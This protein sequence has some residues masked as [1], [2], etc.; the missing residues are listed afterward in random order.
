MHKSIQFF[1]I[2]G[3]IL[4]ACT[5]T[6]N[7]SPPT[8]APTAPT[9]IIPTPPA[10]EPACNSIEVEPTP[11]PDVPSL[12]PPVSADEHVRGPEDAIMTLVV[13]ND[14]QCVDCN[15]LS[16][17]RE[18]FEKQ[19]GNVRI[20]YRYYPYT[21]FFD[22]GELAA[23]AAE[24]ASNQDKFWEMHDL[25]FEKQVEWVDLPVDDFESWVTAQAQEIG[26]DKTQFTADFNSAETIETVQK[27]VQEGTR[28][29]IPKLP[30]ILMNGQIY[31][32]P[33]DYESF[34]QVISLLKLGERQF[35]QCPPTVIDMNKQYIAKLETE[36]GEIVLQLYPDKAPLTVNSFVYLA[37]QGWFDGITFHRVLPGFVAQTGDP[38]GTGQGN[39]GYI[40][41]NEIDP[42][43]KFDQAGLVAMAN[44]GPDS[45]GSQFFITYGPAPHLDGGYTIFGKVLS[46]MEVVEQLTPRDPQPGSNLPPGDKLVSVTIEEK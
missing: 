5:P 18:L 14:F 39:P 36:K 31:N 33:V 16:L 34:S 8:V 38:S 9:I 20:A 12:F 21:N 17:S 13:Y 32:G 40:F 37:R 22:K 41:Q 19:P 15:Y 24:A 30:F 42:T 46:G 7:D 26:L 3:L 29:G 25:L 10:T 27:S 44:S 1:I 43:L 45:N 23:R 11:G 2:L 4:S 35:S 6:D 28:V